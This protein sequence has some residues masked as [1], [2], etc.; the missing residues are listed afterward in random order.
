MLL[1][2]RPL[3]QP[4]TR[5]CGW[6]ISLAGL[7]TFVG[8]AVPQFS[9]GPVIGAGGYLGAAGRGLL[10]MNFAT[11]G[12]YIVAV[13]LILG[14]LLLSTDYLLL[15]ILAF[16][17]GKPAHGIGQGMMQ[18]GAAAAKR[19]R[20]KS[21]LDGYDPFG[22]DAAGDGPKILAVRVKGRPS[23]EPKPIAAAEISPAKPEKKVGPAAGN[24]DTEQPAPVAAEAKGG[25]GS[26]L[27]VR[28][29]PAPKVAEDL[30]LDEPPQNA[31]D[32]ELPSIEPPAA[33]RE[34]QLRRTG[35]RGP[36][37]GQDPRKDVR[38]FRLQ[39]Q[40]GRDRDRA[41]HRADSKSSSRPACG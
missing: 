28:K 40:S 23:E 39:R 2:R 33:Q 29:P 15:Q 9:P 13:S 27:R 24:A 16:V 4:L 31:A 34:F 8:M 22:D 18:V 30:P 3:A 17:V 1:A 12:A 10:E 5:L 25:L 35:S 38:E 6:L 41:G 20:R 19:L 11:I 7:T 26:L 21:D 36:P 32:Y 14:G 37:Q